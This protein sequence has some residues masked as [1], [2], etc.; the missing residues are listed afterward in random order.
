MHLNRTGRRCLELQRSTDH[1]RLH[2]RFF[3]GFKNYHKRMREEQE[4]NPPPVVKR[5]RALIQAR[6]QQ[7]VAEE[8][9][10]YTA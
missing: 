5:L 7:A 3:V 8:P 6:H 1:P 4:R 10:P 2:R 9:S